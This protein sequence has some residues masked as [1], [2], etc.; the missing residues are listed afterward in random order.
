[1]TGKKKDLGNT[2]KVT[3]GTQKKRRTK[4][5][6][7]M[8]HSGKLKEVKPPKGGKY[9]GGGAQGGG[10]RAGGVSVGGAGLGEF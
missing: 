2:G 6:G 3:E 7:L 4:G 9:S 5:E 10:E 1:L 8:G